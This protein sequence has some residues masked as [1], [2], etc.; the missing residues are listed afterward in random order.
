M[1][2]ALLAVF[3]LASS[4]F[5][6][7]ANICD[8]NASLPVN[9]GTVN[10]G[11][12][13]GFSTGM[14][15]GFGGM[16][17]LNGTLSFD[18]D[19]L[20]NLA[21]G[22]SV[23]NPGCTP[24][25]NDTIVI[26]VDS[27]T[28]GFNDTSTFTDNADQGR[29]AASGMGTNGARAQLNFA[30]GFAPDYAIVIQNGFSGLFELV[31]GGS[32]V[33]V[34]TLTRSSVVTVPPPCV[35]EW[36]GFT[37][38]DLGAQLGTDL[39][40]VATLLNATDATRSNEFHGVI[41]VPAG[42]IGA[43]PHTFAAGEFNVFRP[44]PGISYLTGPVRWTFETYAGTGFQPTAICG[45]LTS[46][47]F[48]A[49]GWS[50]GDL[51]FGGTRTTASTDFTRGVLSAPTTQGGFFAMTVSPGNRAFGFQPGGSDFAPGVLTLAI[52]N[53]SATTYSG[54]DLSY[55]IW[56][57]NDAPRGNTLNF[58]F[59]VDGINFVDLP[60]LNFTS[61]AAADA[62]GFQQTLRTATLG[63]FEIPPSSRLYLRFSTNDLLG[64]GARDE[65][66]ID[67][68]V[69]VPRTNVFADFGD[70]P[71]S[72]G[73]AGHMTSVVFM[74][75]SADG[76]F[77]QQ[78]SANA[79]LDDTNGND[80]EDGV[81]FGGFYEGASTQLTVNSNGVAR[82]SV[83]VD[84]N[85]DGAFGAGEQPVNNAALVAGNNLVNVP[86][87]VGVTRG[88][89]FMRVRVASVN[90]SQATG[91]MA[92]GEVEDYAITIG[93]CGD[94]IVNG[95]EQCDSGGVSGGECGCQLNCT[96]TPTTAQCG[97]ALNGSCDAQDMCDGAGSCSAIVLSAG[98]ECR[99]GNGV[100]DVAETCTGASR[101]C[102]SDGFASS[103]VCRVSAGPC[104]LAE[105]CDGSGVA[106]PA[107]LLA[108]SGVCRP[109]VDVCDVA[110]SCNGSG[111]ACPADGFA[112]A[113]TTCRG[114]T[115]TCDVAEQCTG[116]AAACPADGF[117][118]STVVCR[119]ANGLCDV[120]ETCTGSSDVCPAD[121]FA[122]ANTECRATN[123]VCDVAE[124]CSGSSGACPTDN[125]ATSGVCRPSA[126]DCDVA[127]SCNG[128]TANCP[129]DGFVATGTE[130]R[131]SAGICDVAE[132]CSGT[133]AA[134]PNDG[135][136]SSATECR[137]SA[138]PCDIGEA[139]TGGSA[140]CPV[141]QLRNSATVCRS[142]N[143]LCDSQ[144]TCDG[145]TA[146][147]PNDAF[148]GSG[149]I[150]RNS[151][152]GCDVV[153]TCSGTSGA[154]PNDGFAPNTTQC[155]AAN[156][157]CDVAENCS[158]TAATCPNDGFAPTTQEC[159]AAN[160]VCD[161]AENCSGSSGSCPSDGFA[162]SSTVCRMANGLCDVTESCSGTSG[163]CPNDG[164]AA[165]GT[166]CRAANGVCDVA[167]SCNGTSGACPNDGFAPT[168]TVCRPAAQ[169][170]DAVE[171]CTGTT[172]TCPMDLASAD[173][174][175][176]NDTLTCNGTERCMSG[177]CTAGTNLNCADSDA[178]TMDMCAEPSGCTNMRIPGCCLVTMDCDDNDVCTDD[179]CPGAG[180]MCTHVP[181]PGCV[182]DGGVD[183]GVD[184]G[185]ADGGEVDG[186][187]EDAGMD[188]A[189]MGTG[190]G[191]GATGGGGGTTGG[192]MATGGGATGGGATGGGA[193]GGGSATGGGAGGGGDG[194]MPGCGCT[195][196]DP[197]LVL[198]LALLA[199]AR[200]RFRRQ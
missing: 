150:C 68:V 53:I 93:G 120:P 117:A 171:N 185:E 65:I 198:G 42:N 47:Q 124:V 176:C 199:L 54:A 146:A 107:D 77:A 119:S 33:F 97:P 4:T 67:D 74:G 7:T 114:S 142:A 27:R 197:S 22:L 83:W 85:Q 46:D 186:G 157:I 178:C 31:G 61:P 19:A 63:G 39:R 29:A 59:S 73:S 13:A 52:Q 160:G 179:A 154:C 58:A 76:E 51:A 44:G 159:R 137:A 103:G 180:Q 125:F 34:K 192:G 80:D 88:A 100:C 16:L 11:E 20:G 17:G 196:V 3:T 183:G 118:P 191:G 172:S 148:L 140:T 170:C 131:G 48:A 174:T 108:T 25:A 173:G 141:D 143:G 90:P 60:A 162:P 104:D 127:E 165:S 161:V 115:G 152:G 145:V 111:A 71:A 28:G 182:S 15:N 96:W 181:V 188:D 32:H 136:A 12:Y 94:S 149:T 110:E 81:T 40:Y 105:S 37:M 106:C 78:S 57:R 45:Q 155:R 101:D 84:W 139:C 109:G 69:V 72:Y 98:T 164:F 126:G 8:G 35:S 87:P 18:S 49:T 10:V 163:S 133:S 112:P 43:A 138:G 21:F 189:G 175:T 24:G 9:D 134:C 102:P 144:E 158:G 1:R 92:D 147:C 55:S 56:V 195:T 62:L 23:N 95:T 200:R 75:V 64:S 193:T 113:T 14:G 123:G 168:S 36:T 89:T 26:Y 151:A 50:D 66:A 91:P 167:E 116:F 184:G 30:S 187:G 6:A 122:A 70:A 130:C 153:E 86:V 82:V 128:G 156:G 5:A 38:A 99:A 135:F 169:A 190:G 166:Q 121:G 2:L 79:Q 41:S 177:A 132:A 129:N 194:Q